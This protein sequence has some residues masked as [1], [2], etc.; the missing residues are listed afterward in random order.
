M[1]KRSFWAWVL[2]S[3]V[4]GPIAWYLIFVRL[5]IYTAREMRM[6]GPKCGRIISKDAKTCRYCKT[7]IDRESRDRAA[8]LGKQAATMV[9]AARH[10]LGRTRRAAEKAASAASENEGSR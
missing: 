7:W 1:K 2:L 3:L 6:P 8:E 4:T 9:F 10:L 5:G